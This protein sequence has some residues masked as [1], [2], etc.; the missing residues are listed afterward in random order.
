MLNSLRAGP[1]KKGTSSLQNR[2]SCF[3]PAFPLPFISNSCR[4]GKSEQKLNRIMFKAKEQIILSI[5][6]EPL[7]ETRAGPLQVLW[8]LLNPLPVVE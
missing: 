7:F 4:Q 8:W 2:P 3:P 1:S 5:K 6:V